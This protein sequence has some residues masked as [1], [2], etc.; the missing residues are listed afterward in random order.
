MHP[1]SNP[2]RPRSAPRAAMSSGSGAPAGTVGRSASIARSLR[3]G[4]SSPEARTRAWSPEA[5]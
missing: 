5:W 1:V 2:A 4:A 3:K